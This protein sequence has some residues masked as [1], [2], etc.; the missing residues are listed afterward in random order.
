M[1]NFDCGFFG[2]SRRKAVTL[3]PNIRIFLELCYEALLNGG[4]LEGGSG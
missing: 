2:I 3:D 4:A 1:K